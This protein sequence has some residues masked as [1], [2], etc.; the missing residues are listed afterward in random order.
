MPTFE[1][2][3]KQYTDVD[4]PAAH[5]AYVAQG[6]RKRFADQFDMSGLS[7]QEV[8]QRH[9]ARYGADMS[10]EDYA[11]KLNETYAKDYTPPVVPE[12]TLPER[13][14]GAATAVGHGAKEFATSLVP[15]LVPEAP[16]AAGAIAGKAVKAAAEGASKAIPGVS[17]V[18]FAAGHGINMGVQAATAH[19]L[20]QT[21]ANI[22]VPKAD[23][24]AQQ[25][26]EK[27]KPG[28]TAQGYSPDQIM[29]EARHR[30]QNV[31]T[32]YQKTT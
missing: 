8:I 31:V 12:E 2:R 27:L 3:Q 18:A 25:Y 17:Q 28:L 16:K 15:F 4:E 14:Q 9:H 23:E 32:G 1:D 13:V 10:P 11:K 19:A 5:R 26:F 24:I 7:D 22:P 29:E 20:E 6:I 30:A 21:A